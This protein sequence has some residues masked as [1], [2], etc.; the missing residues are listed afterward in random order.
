MKSI[1]KVITSNNVFPIT[2]I[3]HDAM[4]RFK[5]EI[6][7]FFYWNLITFSNPISYIYFIDYCLAILW[8]LLIRRVFSPLKV[9]ELSS[10]RPSSIDG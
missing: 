10:G 6:I 9:P 2:T 7:D 8:K 4:L 1:M 5:T 3:S